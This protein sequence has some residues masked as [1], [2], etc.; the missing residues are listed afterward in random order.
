MER[1]AEREQGV[2]VKS[3]YLEAGAYE[4]TSVCAIATVC[5]GHE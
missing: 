4:Y 5:H 1:E 2:Q 3:V